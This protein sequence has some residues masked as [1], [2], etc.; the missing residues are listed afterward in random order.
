MDIEVKLARISVREVPKQP[1]S[2]ETVRLLS[3]SPSSAILSYLC[4][5]TVLI[6]TFTKTSGR[7]FTIRVV[8]I[9]YKCTRGARQHKQGLGIASAYHLS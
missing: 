6:V 2:L 3:V 1:M 9:V 5:P 8:V 7:A 4:D